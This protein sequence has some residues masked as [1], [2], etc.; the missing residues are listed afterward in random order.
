MQH[1]SLDTRQAQVLNY[2]GSQLF[3]LWIEPVSA[4]RLKLPSGFKTIHTPGYSM[5]D[6]AWSHLTA[7]VLGLTLA[8]SV[9]L[10]W[11]ASAA[12]SEATRA[13][14][15]L[16]AYTSQVKTGEKIVSW[17]NCL[18][19]DLELCCFWKLRTEIIF[20]VICGKHK[21]YHLSVLIN[22]TKRFLKFICPF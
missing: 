2:V 3:L 21:Q 7:L 18:G 5:K 13:A 16:S 17:S 9:P 12:S 6:S 11:A 19:R 1:R 14:R 20:R 22:Y 15:S 8:A 4:V 10:S